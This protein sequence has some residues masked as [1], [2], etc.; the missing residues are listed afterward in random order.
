MPRKRSISNISGETNQPYS[1]RT[2]LKA[3]KVPCNCPKCKGKLVLNRTKLLYESGNIG[4]GSQTSSNSSSNIPIIEAELPQMDTVDSIS[5]PTAYSMSSIQRAI[6]AEIPPIDIEEELSDVDVDTYINHEYFI[7]SRIRER[8]YIGRVQTTID[9]GSE[10]T[11]DEMSDIGDENEPSL[12]DEIFEDYTTPDFDLYNTEETTVNEDF[13]WIL[14][15]I[16]KFRTK[17]NIP[18]TATESLIKFMKLVLSEIGGDDFKDF[19]DS[20]YLAKQALGLKDRFQSF[21]PCSKCHKLYLKKEVEQYCQ[22]ETPTIMKC[23]HI[24][25]PNSASRRS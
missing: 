13:L 18:E 2:R 10:S 9:E 5:T 4:S 24:E 11:E 19:P 16:M 20:I 17:F 14:L 1:A 25:Y 21:V 22:G 6:D 7:A 8:R 3:I 23:R 12:G 15:W